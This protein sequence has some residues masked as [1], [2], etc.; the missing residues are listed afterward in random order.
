MVEVDVQTDLEIQVQDLIGGH[1]L[2]VIDDVV[3]SAPISYNCNSSTV[4][5]AATSKQPQIFVLQDG[6]IAFYESASL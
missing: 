4:I 1:H 6:Y 5:A 2:L 3:Q